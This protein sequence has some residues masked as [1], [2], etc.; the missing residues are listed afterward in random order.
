M[1]EQ[2]LPR[3]RECGHVL[4]RRYKKCPLCGTV[5]EKAPRPSLLSNAWVL[6]GAGLVLLAVVISLILNPPGST[7]G[8]QTQKTITHQDS[9]EPVATEKVTQSRGE[10]FS[11]I[12][13]TSTEVAKGFGQSAVQALASGQA[14]LRSG[15]YD[16]AILAF[17]EVLRYEPNSAEALANRGLAYLS[18]TD[19]DMAIADFTATI[20]LR[21]TSD[22][23]ANRAA[24]HF[25]KAE[26]DHAIQDY[27]DAIRLSP[28][29]PEFFNGRGASYAGLHD[30]DR[31][32]Q[33]YDRAIL[34]KPDPIA[35]NNRGWA[36]S[37]KG[38]QERA[39]ADYLGALK[40]K[41]NDF[42]RQHVEVALRSLG[43]K[44]DMGE[45]PH[46]RHRQ[47]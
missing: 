3:C 38:N 23:F 24:A 18:K 41:P 43:F 13:P 5:V 42:V 35:L 32:I 20:Q 28:S 10:E 17:N 22:V 47:R 15:D 39:I 46:R 44:P 31:A 8:F 29:D 2:P 9:G 25:N 26:Y 12:R 27:T 19:Y 40:L 4:G 33:D 30:Y 34:L 37:Q 1:N 11:A 36:Y 45:R 16:G 6:A 14:S 21:P 7:V